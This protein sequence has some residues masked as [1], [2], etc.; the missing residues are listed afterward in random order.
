MSRCALFLLHCQG[1]ETVLNR[2]PGAWLQCVVAPLAALTPAICPHS[3]MQLRPEPRAPGTAALLCAPQAAL[4]SS[5]LAAIGD[6]GDEGLIEAAS[7]VLLELMSSGHAAAHPDTER[8]SPLPP[9]VPTLAHTLT[10]P[11]CQPS[12]E[13]FLERAGGGG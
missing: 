3:R 1:W 8:V 11:C 13:T 4:L 2:E 7:D 9:S 5:L 12:C 6:D 10:F